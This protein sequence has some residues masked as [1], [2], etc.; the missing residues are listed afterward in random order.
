[1]KL[2]MKMVRLTF[3]SLPL[4]IM[5]KTLVFTAFFALCTTCCA[6]T[7]SKTRCHKHPSTATAT[8][9]TA[10]LL[11]VNHVVISPPP[12]PHNS[13]TPKNAEKQRLTPGAWGRGWLLLLR[14]LLPQLL[15]LLL[16]LLLLPLLSLLHAATPKAAARSAAA[17]ALAPTLPG[18]FFCFPSYSAF[19]NL[20]VLGFEGLEFGALGFRF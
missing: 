20:R 19:V 2:M 10:L 15:L 3:M 4:A 5:P 6:R 12:P 16:L 17:A 14:P 13:K 18:C 7:W 8:G 9:A 11:A 1:M